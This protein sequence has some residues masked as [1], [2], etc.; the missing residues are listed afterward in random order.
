MT[1]RRASIRIAAACLSAGVVALGTADAAPNKNL[2]AAS[3]ARIRERV[4]ADARVSVNPA[5]GV[6]RFVS[7]PAGRPADLAPVAG[8]PAQKA[9]AFF[10]QYADAFGIKDAA[11]ELSLKG[12]STDRSGMTHLDFA[13]VYE[14][15][16]VFAGVLKAHFDAA[17]ALRTVNGTFVPEINVSPI[18]RVTAGEAGRIALERVQEQK[19]Q[20]TA[21][22]VLAAKL[23]VYRTGLAQGVA[24]KSHLAYEVEVGNKKDVREL[25]YVDAH[26]GAVVDQVSGIHEALARRVY[27]GGYGPTFEVW[28]E[29]DPLPHPDV[30]INNIIEFTGDTYDVFFNAFGRDSYTGTGTLMEI[31]NDDPTINCPN[32][33][34]NGVSTNYC[35]GVTGDDTVAHEWAH[36]YTQFTHGLIY[37]WQPG[38]LN[39][40]YSDIFGEVVDTVNGPNVPDNPRT[41]GQCSQFGGA[42]PPTFTVN[43]GSAAGTYLASA[44]VNEPPA[45]TYGP[46]PMAVAVPASACTPVTGVAGA[47]AIVDW[48]LL[49]DGSNECGSGVRATNVLNAGGLGVI[50]VAQP[51]GFLNLGSIAAIPS[52]QITAAD[53]ALIKASLPATST[54]VLNTGTENSFRWLSGEDDPGFGG[55]I[56]DMWNP[57]CFGDPAA[58][59]SGFY[60]CAATDGGGVHTNSGVPNHG[61][62]LLVDGG[63]FGGHTVNAIGMTKAAHI[64]YRAMTV[65][66]HPA[67]DFAD[68]ADSLEQSCVD[69][70]GQPLADLFGGAA[71]T[72][73]AGDCTQV[74]EMIAG[75]NLRTPPTF[76]NFQPMLQAGDPPL[77]PAGGGIA[78]TFFFDNFESA[79][80]S[81][82]LG[83][84]GTA[85]DFTPRAWTWTNA[86]PPGRSGSAFFAP[87]PDIGT[88]A[89]GGDE[90]GVITM[91]SPSVAVPATGAARLAYDHWMSTEGPWDGGN[92]K[93]SVNGGPFTLVADADYTFNSYNGAIDPT[94]TNPMAGQAAF[95]GGDGGSVSGSWGRSVVNL[96]PY[97]NAGDTV[98][99]RYDLGSDGCTGFF[100]WYVDDVRLFSCAA[101]TGTPALAIGDASVVEGN[102]GNVDLVL[103]VT[104]STASG[105]TVTVDYA[106]ADGTAGAGDYNPAT[107]T[108]TFA[109][110]ELSHGVTVSVVGDTTF[111]ADE[112][113]FANL[114]NASGATILDGQGV[115]TIINDD[116]VTAAGGT[117]SEIIHGTRV[118]K[119]LT[120]VGTVAGADFYAVANQPFTSYEVVVDATSGDL[121]T[122]GPELTRVASDGTTVLQ[123]SSPVGTGSSRS[124]RWSSTAAGNEYVRVQSTTC[125]TNCGPD[126]VYRLRA[127]ETTYA[128]PRFNN[129]GTQVTVL[130]LQNPTD[131][132][133]TG[134]IYFWDA[135]GA[136]LH[137]EPVNLAPKALLVFNSATIPALNGQS[138]AITVTHDGAYGALA[139][140]SV[141]LEPATGFSFDSPMAPRSR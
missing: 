134:H 89:V 95:T 15:V 8:A 42:T 106:T 135:A 39:E 91:T 54:M 122:A 35:T 101:A 102:T 100:G 86:L 13:Q 31:V 4:G 44:S 109:P 128:I 92:V 12:T 117:R 113:F 29:G 19:A 6:A 5:T 70:T 98:Q 65:Y 33:N 36:A 85:P 9:R 72:I 27:D 125:T 110:G 130:L 7:V 74:A 52:V 137:D 116:G 78:Q 48:T 58:V 90:S 34:W 131:A 118:Q 25:V 47:F 121:G 20:S 51:T 126:D 139:G 73:T 79:P 18:A 3:A 41:A 62:A 50:F 76:C 114:S 119:A 133:V 123:S 16:P 141:A 68:H 38:A 67:T 99:L 37:A 84:Y 111:E 83:S 93:I 11:R 69:L 32:A 28:N 49:P 1:H 24:G 2:T 46:T 21:P 75:I 129:S 40:S 136:Q 105:S 80:A 61:F 107:G 26:T 120:P 10:G 55:A 88:C 127:Y 108:L 77:C 45:G 17:G 23:Y 56:R 124:L 138:G 103:P 60:T 112:F 22:A 43:T 63:T 81:W 94:S 71:Q 30:D 82:T 66:Q 57:N 59:S 87:N 64:Y 132:A 53:G 115:G 96:A 104:L 140:K 14:G 97:A